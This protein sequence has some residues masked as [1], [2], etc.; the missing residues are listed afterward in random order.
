[1]SVR[2]YGCVWAC[3]GVCGWA[4]EINGLARE[5]VEGTAAV[6]AR[7]SP[8]S[9]AVLAF[10][11]DSIR[12]ELL[13]ARDTDGSVRFSKARHKPPRTFLDALLVIQEGS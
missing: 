4:Q 6:E 3:A 11:P 5:G 1:M 7:L 13:G 12:D 8:W 9:K 2:V 10:L